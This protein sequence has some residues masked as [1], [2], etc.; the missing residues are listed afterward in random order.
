[1]TVAA[2]RTSGGTLEGV[3]DEGIEV[4]R[5]VPYAAAPVGALRWRSPVPAPPWV[6]TLD[7]TRFGSIAPQDISA[8]RLAKRGITMSE[9]CLS[10]N[11]W[12]PG[13]GG[14][15]RPVV[16]FLHG[17]GVV[18]GSGSAPLFDGT[19][20]ARRG[21]LVVVTLNFR[22][23]ALGSL[24]APEVLGVDGDPATNLALRDQLLALRWVRD[25]IG[26]FGGDP[27][28]VTV[29]GQSSGAVAIACMLA[30]DAARGLFD[31][32]ILQSGGLERVRSTDAARDVAL[33]VLGHLGVD[34]AAPIDR[35]GPTVAAILDAQGQVPTGFVPPVGPFHHCVDGEL[36]VEHPLVAA[37][38]RALLPVPILAG[39]TRDEWRVF[40][41]VLD[42]A[43]VT[44]RFLRGRA[45]AL[46][47]GGPDVDD[48]LDRYRTAH[49]G[50]GSI[51]PQ[52]A[53]ASA[54]VT[55]FH[56]TAPTEQLLRAHAG[57]G[58]RAYRYELQW[59]S[60]RPGLGACHD[61]CLP[62]V[63]G[64]LDRAPVLAG[65]DPAAQEMSGI[66]QD[67]WIAFIRTGDPATPATG[68]WPSYDGDRRATMLLDREPHV[69]DRH[70]DDELVVW[71][72]RYP[73]SG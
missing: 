44:D 3:R 31:R 18:A 51:T 56:F 38:R 6:G 7:A 2:A 17:G 21:D 53:V 52:R 14:E 4:F 57:H 30:G 39:T 69:A 71:E 68:A 40:D 73:A 48:I 37:G 65:D 34:G 47:G 42:D 20:L 67:A 29:M 49:P 61:T 55:D 27:G 5:G 41:T 33:Q 36:V 26:A 63:F 70:R 35:T 10:L 28:D 62:L 46:A 45:R 66:V 64:T 25:E 13:A 8:E 54:L 22:L 9:D 12:T 16:V 23:G 32:A 11:V 15:R 43:E 58:L 19:A 72:G 50:D 60:P 24:C 1:M 59:P